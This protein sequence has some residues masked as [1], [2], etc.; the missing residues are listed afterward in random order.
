MIVYFLLLVCLVIMVFT[1]LRRVFYTIEGFSTQETIV[2]LFTKQLNEQKFK[3]CI[4]ML[5]QTPKHLNTILLDLM[6]E[7]YVQYDTTI[8][9][10]LHDTLIDEKIIDENETIN[11][12]CK[13]FK[14]DC[15]SS[16]VNNVCCALL[17]N[18]QKTLKED[19]D[20]KKYQNFYNDMKS[21]VNEV[22]ETKT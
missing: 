11:V 14:K 13:F 12:K 20:Y 6:Y 16:N 17:K 9:T 10:K 2:E 19:A 8:Q 1:Y 21:L 3:T 22:E 18:V 4:D 7:R 5:K 15:D